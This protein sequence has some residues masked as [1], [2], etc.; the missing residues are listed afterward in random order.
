MVYSDMTTSARLLSLLPLS[1]NWKVSS[2]VWFK[3]VLG[4]ARFNNDYIESM[5]QRLHDMTQ[6][7]KQ[8]TG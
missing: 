4:G 3:R 7:Y 6:V 1:C 8:V 2:S 5:Q